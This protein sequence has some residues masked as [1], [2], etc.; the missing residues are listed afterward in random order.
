[1]PT[2]LLTTAADAAAAAVAGG[3]GILCLLILWLLFVIIGIVWLIFSFV[4]WRKLNRII[5]NT[6]TAVE[7]LY[8]LYTVARQEFEKPSIQP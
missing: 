7:N 5:Q 8:G 1:M 4:V 6:R 2:L 3:I